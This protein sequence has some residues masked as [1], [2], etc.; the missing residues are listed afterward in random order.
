M[1]S[2][3]FTM[4]SHFYAI[5]STSNCNQHHSTTRTQENP[6]AFPA[7]PLSKVKSH[8]FPNDVLLQII[9]QTEGRVTP[10]GEMYEG[11]IP[12]HI[13]FPFNRFLDSFSL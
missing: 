12:N 10:N 3:T 7:Y 11:T 13:T 6:A 2:S 8:S 1:I 5:R 4:L 9:N